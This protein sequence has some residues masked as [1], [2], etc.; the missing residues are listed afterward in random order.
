[1][2]LIEHLE[3]LRSRVFICAIAVAVTTTAAFIFN[4]QILNLLLQPLPAAADALTRGG[5]QTKLVITDI[6]GAFTVTLKVSLA[7]GLAV[8][9]PVWLYELWAFIAPGLTRREKKYAGPFTLIGVI[10]FVVGMAVGFVTLRFPIN[11]L[12]SF[13]QSNYLQLVTANS[14]FTFVAYFLLAFGICFELPLVM[15]FLSFVGVI[16]SRK[17]AKNRAYVLVGLWILSTIITP[18]ADP[19]SPVIV[20]VSLTVLYFLSEIFIRVIGK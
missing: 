15:T 12:V 4:Q 2:T 9:A 16:S 1:M 18:G 5:S 6:G 11:W 14:Y 10:L 7:V 8:A 20:G 17:L 13:D 19:Y 3:E